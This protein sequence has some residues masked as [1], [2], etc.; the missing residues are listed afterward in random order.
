M[1]LDPWDDAAE[2]SRR[3]I[4]PGSQLL[5]VIGAEAWCARC[6]VLRPEFDALAQNTEDERI[7]LWLDV[8]D[9]AVFLDTYLPDD[10]PELLVYRDGCCTYRGAVSGHLGA[11]SALIADVCDSSGSADDPGI[12]GRLLAVDWARA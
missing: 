12:F 10:L 11:L 1:I 3:L 5:L 8:E 9:H 2:L 7:C 4:L 6:R